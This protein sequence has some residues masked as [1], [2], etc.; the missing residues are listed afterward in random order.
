[1][2]TLNSLEY[3][4]TVAVPIIKNDTN[5]KGGKLRHL[6]FSYATATAT[7]VSNGDVIIIGGLGTGDRISSGYVTFGAMGA[8]ATLSIGTTA[9]A[10]HYANAI[11]VS[12]AG[13]TSFANTAT[14]NFGEILAASTT[15]QLTAGGANYA[16]GKNILGHI[17]FERD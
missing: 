6:W 15:L 17:T 2:A 16:S 12:A 7:P 5:I 14:L 3:A 9:D 4:N 10:V 13:Q 1:M 8:S 11:D